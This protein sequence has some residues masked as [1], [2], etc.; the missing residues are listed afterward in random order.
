M[1][2]GYYED[3]SQ[4]EIL[5]RFLYDKCLDSYIRRMSCLEQGLPDLLFDL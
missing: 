4:K 3:E 2:A 5:R 1:P